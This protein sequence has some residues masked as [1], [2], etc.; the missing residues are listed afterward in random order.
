MQNPS[1][2][3]HWD[4]EIIFRGVA[5]ETEIEP[6]LSWTELRFLESTCLTAATVA[7]SQKDILRTSGFEP[8][9]DSAPPS[10]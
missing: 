4:L 3:Q 10:E 6:I 1:A 7:R 8:G 2:T 9:S 5:S